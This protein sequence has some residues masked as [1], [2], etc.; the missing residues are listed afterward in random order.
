MRKII[1]LTVFWLSNMIA[2]NAQNLGDLQKIMQSIKKN[3]FGEIAT[4]CIDL[5]NDRDYDYIFSYSCG[6]TNCFEVYLTI[7]GKLEKVIQEFGYISY[8]YKNSIE[9]QP[10][11]FILESYLTHCCGESP[12]ES[13][14]KF[15]FK[16]DHY[17]VVENYVNYNH[18]NYCLDDR[19]EDNLFFPSHFLTNIYTVKIK[20][21]KINIRFSADLEEHK[22]DFV[23][24][25]NSNIIGQ[26]KKNA[27]VTV[28][29]EEKGKDKNLRTWL[30][31]EINKSDLNI[32][33][34]SSPL[35]FDFEGQKLR[36][37][38]CDKNTIRK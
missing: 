38:I 33:T 11:H 37:W 16:N 6:E 32:E 17:E 20:E 21:E 18:E 29:A 15:I 27:E 12:F 4:K 3:T 26:L 13:H 34:C 22:A 2:V 7:N 9:F 14:R 24:V 25:E 1:A 10:S 31:V 36:G 30:Y 8:S 23:C 35:T 28:L 5:D 19:I